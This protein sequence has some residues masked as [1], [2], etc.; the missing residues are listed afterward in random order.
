MNNKNLQWPS[1]PQKYPKCQLP[2]PSENNSLSFTMGYR[3][4]LEMPN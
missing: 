1:D 2:P 4:L 3:F